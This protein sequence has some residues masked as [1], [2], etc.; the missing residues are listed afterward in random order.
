V[1]GAD[2]VAPTGNAATA[3][4]FAAAPTQ[5]S[6]G[7]APTGIAANGNASNCTLM[8]GG[9][10]SVTKWYPAPASVTAVVSNGYRVTTAS[11][12]LTLPASPADGSLV[13]VMNYL[14]SGVFTIAAGSGNTVFGLASVSVDILYAGFTLVYFSATN[15]WRAI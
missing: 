14:S 15:D 13:G 7:Y 10:G 12:T 11:I 3:T 2:Y 8:G 5:C 1:A 4:A 9:G 6:A